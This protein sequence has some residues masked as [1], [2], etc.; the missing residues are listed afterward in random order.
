MFARQSLQDLVAT[1]RNAYAQKNEIE[2]DDFAN[3]K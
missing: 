3:K 2:V 1:R